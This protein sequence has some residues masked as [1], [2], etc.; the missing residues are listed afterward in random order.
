MA[1]DLR[2]DF[3]DLQLFIGDKLDVGN[4][5][6][7]LEQALEEFCAYPRDLQA[8]K[9]GTRRSLEESSR[10]ESSPLDIDDVLE[11]GEQRLAQ[12]GVSD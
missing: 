1:T 4:S 8:F 9:N 11:R 10:A 3:Q 2:D 12:K 7:S 6:I 5:A